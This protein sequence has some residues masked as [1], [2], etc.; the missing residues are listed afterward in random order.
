ML[1]LVLSDAG[2]ETKPIVAP[3]LANA[4][5]Q[6]RGR[7]GAGL[8]GDGVTPINVAVLLPNLT[9]TVNPAA[10]PSQATLTMSGDAQTQ[11]T[12]RQNAK[13][14]LANNTI[15][16]AL[17]PPT[18]AQVVAQVAALTRQVDAL[19]RLAVGDFTGTT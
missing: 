19:I 3:D 4:A 8:N 10:D 12:I 6:I 17:N 14:A 7:F 5:D 1:F 18:Q 13:T 15:Y 9:G 2:L 11:A 16:L